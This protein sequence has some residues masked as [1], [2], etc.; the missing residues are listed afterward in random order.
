MSTY[1]DRC[2]VRLERRTIPGES[3]ADVLAEIE[4]ACSVV[5]TRRPNFHAT[6]RLLFSQAPS[7]VAISAPIVSALSASMEDRGIAAQIAGMSAWTDAALL[8]AVGIPAVCF[9]PGD[10][11]LAHAA[12]EYIPLL[13]IDSAADVF[14]ALAC[15]WCG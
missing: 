2:V 10:I 6:T 11:S 13:E 7:D 5:L 14:H 8:N 4:R 15:R 9:G 1:P 12:E 3:D